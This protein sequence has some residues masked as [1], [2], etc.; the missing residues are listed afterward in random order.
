MNTVTNKP[1]NIGID[2]GSV[3]V[4]SII[5]DD[6][7]QI[8]EDR[9]VRHTGKPVEITYQIIKERGIDIPDE[10]GFVMFDDPDWTRLVTPQVTAVSQ[11][12]YTIGSTAAELLFKRINDGSNYIDKEPEKIVLQAKLVVRG[13]A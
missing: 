12:A 2:V 13:S 6:N 8:L 10:L 3:S 4:D 1:I 5:I 9:Y 7:C 11:P